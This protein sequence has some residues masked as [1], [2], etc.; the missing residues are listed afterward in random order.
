MDSKKDAPINVEELE[1]SMTY[2]NGASM[3]VTRSFVKKAGLCQD[4]FLYY[5]EVDW[6]LQAEPNQLRYAHNCVVY[7]RHGSMIGSNRDKTKLSQLSV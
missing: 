3:F 2:V 1:G 6:C 4:S 7:R 5:V